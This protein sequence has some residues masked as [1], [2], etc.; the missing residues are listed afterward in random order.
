MRMLWSEPAGRVS[1]CAMLASWLRVGGWT[2]WT[3][4]SDSEERS[5]TFWLD[6]PRL[7]RIRFFW[8]VAFRY[9]TV[10][11]CSTFLFGK[12]RVV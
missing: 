12:M 8:N 10:H 11:P 7:T 4:V 1:S 2:G 9:G 5:L 6:L 3:R